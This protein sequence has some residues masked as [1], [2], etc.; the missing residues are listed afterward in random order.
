MSPFFNLVNKSSY[1]L[2]VGEVSSHSSTRWHYVSSA[3][4]TLHPSCR[5]WDSFA[6]LS[7]LGGFLLASSL[8]CLLGSA[9]LF[10]QRTHQG[11][12]V[13]VWSGRNSLPATS[14]L[15]SRTTAPC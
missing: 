5:C 15:T 2:E 10:G 9:S 12:C 6:P 7:L 11:S 4:V 14:C 3:E 1:E 13:C 8:F